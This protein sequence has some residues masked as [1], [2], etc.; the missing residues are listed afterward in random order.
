[1]IAHIVSRRL[2]TLRELDEYYSTEDLFD[3]LEILAVEDNNQS[4]A[5]EANNG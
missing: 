3:M 1:M 5:N 2:A 4:I